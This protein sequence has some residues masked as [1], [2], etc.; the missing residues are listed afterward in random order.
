MRAGIRAEVAKTRVN[1]YENGEREPDEA[2]ARRLA[3]ALDMSLA[4]LYADT[5]TMAQLIKAIS[6]LSEVD[7]V[8]LARQLGVNLDE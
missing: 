2:T 6:N 5:P 3:E 8:A 4:A 1:R 7:Q